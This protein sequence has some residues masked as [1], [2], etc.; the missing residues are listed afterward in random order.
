[1]RKILT[2]TFSALTLAPLPAL[3]APRTFTEAIDLA[4]DIIDTGTGL[5][6][7]AGIVVYFWGISTNI[8]KMKD[9]G[10]AVF[11]NYVIWGIIALFVMVSIWGIIQLLQNT[12]FGGDYYSPS[13]GPAGTYTGPSGG[14]PV[15]EE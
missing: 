15:F 3:A 6:I 10:G 14:F 1:M 8:L 13:I 5:L 4:V 7:L 11:K 2:F 12:I 9:E